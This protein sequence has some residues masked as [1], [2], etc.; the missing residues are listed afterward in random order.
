M[1]GRSVVF[2]SSLI[3]KETQLLDFVESYDLTLDNRWIRIDA[4]DIIARER[5]EIKFR[6]AT[7][8]R[9]AT[10]RQRRRT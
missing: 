9:R 10:L 4:L 7:L 6:E 1:S 3:E 5:R 8:A 2:R